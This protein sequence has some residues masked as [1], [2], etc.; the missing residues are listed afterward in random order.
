MSLHPPIESVKLRAVRMLAVLI[1]AVALLALQ[2]RVTRA[3]PA[4]APAGCPGVKAHAGNTSGDKEAVFGR[5]KQRSQATALLKRVHRKGFRCA[6]IERE[7]SIYEVA[8]IGL[9]TKSAAVRIVRRARRAGFAASV[10]RS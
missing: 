8:I 4:A 10:A 7:Q 9:A 1:C 2:A 5:R 3:Q 6:V